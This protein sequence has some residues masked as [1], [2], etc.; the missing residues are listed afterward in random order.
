[1][2]DKIL[3]YALVQHDENSISIHFKRR[4]SETLD[5]VEILMELPIIASAGEI[6]SLHE[7][8]DTEAEV[9]IAVED[10]NTVRNS[11]NLLRLIGQM[12]GRVSGVSYAEIDNFEI[13][14][15]KGLLFNWDKV[16][17]DVISNVLMAI[18]PNWKAKLVYINKQ[19]GK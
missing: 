2:V 19:E 18:G 9:E 8:D 17:V 14:I 1:M 16:V 12:V 5:G 6:Q 7:D 13:F 11:N 4:L 3:E 15:E 10:D